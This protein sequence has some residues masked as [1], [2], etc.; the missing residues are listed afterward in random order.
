MKR[1]MFVIFCL[2]LLAGCGKKTEEGISGMIT[3]DINP[4]IEMEI[5]DNN[6]NRINPL[7]SE[8]SEIVDRDSMEGKPLKEVL[9]AILLKVK[10]KG[11]V[12]D[13]ELVII[14]GLEEMDNTE[15]KDAL[16][17]EDMVKA[18]CE[19]NDIKVN[20]IVPEITEEAKH[21]A[22]GYGVTPAK[23][24]VILDAMKGNEELHFDDL[25]DKSAKELIQIKESGLY[26]DRDY[27]LNG[28]KCERRERD[29]APKEGKSCPEGYED[30]KDKCY[31][32]ADSKKEPYCKDGLTLKDN[33]CVGTE[34]VSATPAKYACSK[35]VAKTRYEAGLTGKNDGDAKDIVCVDT[36]KATHPVSPC[37]LN[38][39]T[40]W[41][42]SGG[43]CYWHR[44]GVLPEGCPGKIRV[45]DSCWDDASNILICKGARDGK[46]YKSRSEYCEGS[47]K[48]TSPTVSEYKCT[49]GKLSGNKCLVD[50]SKEVEY[51]ISCDDG[52][53]NYLDRVCYNK[54]ETVDY[55]TGLTCDKGGRLENDRCVFYEVIDAKEK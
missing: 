17:V 27:T 30:I 3:I 43:K 23:A 41:T 34:S 19:K 2:L 7:D 15:S 35:G 1:F 48:Y 12:Q 21:E 42:K 54:N 10:E 29:E 53:T 6:A 22:Q 9:E 45:G 8:A 37:E 36:S 44:A 16:S 46:Q 47:V 33:K 13:D 18:A 26:C 32:T 38:D 25:K 50:V 31:K 5:R 11:Y 52:Y 40:E 39:G 20:I 55:V 14:L 24:Q 4:S 49:K 28:D 51:K